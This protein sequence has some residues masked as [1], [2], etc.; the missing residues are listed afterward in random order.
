MAVSIAMPKFVSTIVAGGLIVVFAAC[1][2]DTT[3][4]APRSQADTYWTL[5]L[6]QHAV[7][8]ALTAPDNT[9]R[10]HPTAI[11][12]LGDTI[13]LGGVVQ[14]TTG[15]SSI[16]V[17]RSGLVT[18]K[19]STLSRGK[20]TYIIAS[21]QDTVERLTMTDTVFIQVTPTA[22]SSPLATFSAQF[23]PSDTS[24]HRPVGLGRVLTPTLLDATGTAMSSP[25]LV[26]FT[27]SDPYIATVTSR[28]VGELTDDGGYVIGT[29]TGTVTIHAETW[30][31][32]VAERDSITLAFGDRISA[33]VTV[34]SK[35]PY[36]SL[37]PVLYFSPPSVTI[38]A[39]GVV[40][41]QNTDNTDSIDVVFDDPTS[42]DSA[43]AL[44]HPDFYPYTGR[45]N[46]TGLYNDTAS[47]NNGDFDTYIFHILRARSFPVPG[48]Y[49]YHST[50]YGS[51]GTI[52]AR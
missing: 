16:T 21:L 20:P 40:T 24:T 36:G 10:L 19:Y 27:S 46:F 11:N 50:I 7:T 37:T 3:G 38:A 9:M 34:L 15:D 12:P 18:A 2:S 17:D 26:A 6:D 23:D 52:I 41:W 32:G 49:H 8:L 14:Y 48:T 42:A 1:G 47:S 39:G 51:T 22:P 45:G 13:P 29:R 33:R 28:N 5:R 44:N 4:T 35:T 30:A 31:Y 43:A 25:I